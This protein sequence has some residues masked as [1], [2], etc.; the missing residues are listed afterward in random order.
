[1]NENEESLLAIMFFVIF[2]L[3]SLLLLCKTN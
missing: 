1:M 2:V 3:T